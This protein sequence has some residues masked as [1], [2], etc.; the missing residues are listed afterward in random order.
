MI[1]DALPWP[2]VFELDV[3][4]SV[5][6]QRRAGERVV[7]RTVKLLAI[8]EELEPDHHVAG[9]ERRAT[10]RCAK[11]LV[12]VSGQQATL[13]HRAYQFPVIVNGLRLYVETT[14]RWAQHAQY[15][16]LDNVRGDVRLSAV[17]EGQT[18]GPADVGFPIAGYRW[19]SSPYNNTWDALVPYNK[20]Y[21]H[22]G[23]DY[24]A[25]PDRLH[26]LSPQAGKVIG[27][28]LPDGDGRSN[29]LAIESAGGAVW[30]L[31]HMNIESVDR[32]LTL[33]AS[34]SAGQ[35]L[36]QTGCTWSGRRSQ[37]ADPHLHT[38]LTVGG[39]RLSH[40]P[41]SV[42]AYLRMYPDS[43]LA[44]AGGYLFATVGDEVELDAT[45]SVARPG[46]RIVSYQWKLH[47]GATCDK[48]LARVRCGKAG[49]FAEE[50]TVRA[51]DGSED[52]D[53][54]QLRVWDPAHRGGVAFG[55]AYHSPV[56]GLKAGQ[57]VRLWNRLTGT[58]GPAIV[59][60]GD[61]SP[62][63]KIDDQTTHVYGKSG[64]YIVT[65]EST[66]PAS[67]RAVVKM[68]IVVE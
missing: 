35:K 53:H 38:G 47:D 64:L 25:W 61:G 20:L 24:G 43:V 7:G 16:R 49:L 32:G 51:D 46:R 37:H 66:G 59:D 54:V 31:A 14:R 26:V 13:L 12:D 68:K 57:E 23:E 28:P 39:V 58:T 1:L 65:F 15:D 19:R 60:L 55:W 6:I 36:A 45:R 63:R 4:Q 67:Q 40:Y 17:A 11:V 3:G 48:A 10:H 29:A 27:S 42:E 44:V 21:Y 8:E 22:H 56:R 62:P 41:T 52:R 2:T 18:W 5:E 9:N 33:G 30:R 50:L 34:V